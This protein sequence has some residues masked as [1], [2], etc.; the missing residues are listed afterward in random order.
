MIKFFNKIHAKSGKGF[1]LLET[2]VAL[3]ILNAAILG[4]I[5]LAVNSIRSASLSHNIT[6]ASFLAEEAAELVRAQREEN[7][8]AG[9]NWLANLDGCTT[10]GPCR[11]S[12]DTAGEISIVSCG[13]SCAPLKRD[14]D[15]GLY[16]Y[17]S[18]DTSIFT[19]TFTIEEIKNEKEV[20]VAVTI[21]WKERFLGGNQNVKLESHLSNWH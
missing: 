8:Y 20:K 13:G 6:A 14:F 5:T 4:P 10:G 3:A 16:W 19:R 17:E 2:L 21:S 12:M 15:A 18:G 11:I 9:N 7:I 1:S